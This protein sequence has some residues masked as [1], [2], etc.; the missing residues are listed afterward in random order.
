MLGLR[1]AVAGTR[2]A[3]GVARLAVAPVAK[4]SEVPGKA[5]IPVVIASLARVVATVAGPRLCPPP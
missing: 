5:T 3:I 1:V 2:Q 4:V